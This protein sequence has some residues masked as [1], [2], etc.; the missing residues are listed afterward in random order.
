MG[1][2]LTAYRWSAG[3]RCSGLAVGR[4]TGEPLLSVAAGRALSSS[5][6]ARSVAAGRGATVPGRALSPVAGD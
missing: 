2:G 5:S 4:W 6:S 3:G 1:T